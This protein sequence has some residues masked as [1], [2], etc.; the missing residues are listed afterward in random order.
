MP[1][2]VTSFIINIFS[3]AKY[4]ISA[5]RFIL[6]HLHPNFMANTISDARSLQGAFKSTQEIFPFLLYQERHTQASQLIV[7]AQG[8]QIIHQKSSCR[9]VALDLN[10]FGWATI[11][12]LSDQSYRPAHKS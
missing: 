3:K 5:I 1:T 7:H 8:W 10:K 6:N 2:D 12:I 9:S 11:K 4:R